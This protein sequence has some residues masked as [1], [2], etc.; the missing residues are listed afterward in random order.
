MREFFIIISRSGKCRKG[1]RKEFFRRSHPKVP[2][3]S[4]TN[5]RLTNIQASAVSGRRRFVS[6]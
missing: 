4:T 3:L 2:V 6:L 5:N 1:F